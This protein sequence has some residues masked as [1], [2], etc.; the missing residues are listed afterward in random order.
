M[1]AWI[2]EALAA[3]AATALLAGCS[4][5]KAAN[6]K[7]GPP[8]V[9]VKCV[10]PVERD[11][12]RTLLV[13]MA[14]QP[15]SHAELCARVDGAVELM[16]VDE[17][18]RVK[19][20]DVLFQ[21]DKQNLENKLEIS[22]QELAVMEASLLVSAID[23]EIAKAQQGKAEIDFNRAEHLY[24]ANAVSKD[25]H[26]TVELL[27]TEANAT[28]RKKEALLEYAKAKVGQA[29]SNYVIAKKELEDSMIKAPFDG[30]VVKVLTEL[31]EYA[32]KGEA[33]VRLESEGRLELSALL[34]SGLYGDIEAGRTMAEL[35]STSGYK[36]S[37]PVS[38]K[39][40]NVDS[41][42]RTFEVKV[43][44]PEKAPLVAGQLC[45]VSLVLR[46][47]K[48][49]G[50][51]S[52]CALPREGG[53]FAAFTVKDGKAVERKLKIGIREKDWIEVSSS[54]GA[55]DGLSFAVEGQSFLNDGSP[56]ETVK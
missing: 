42:S 30:V 38:Y 52:Q 5:G 31:W 29:K 9:K 45:E 49:L 12:K 46:T 14:V 8:P 20:G 27:S 3:L 28:V 7:A 40:P 35:S 34:S 25:R 16:N 37:L 41:S 56:V 36:A 4:D 1:K 43:A 54:E 51:P 32:D 44:L 13:Q 48:G 2:A 47:S 26:E 23:C 11:F 50:L 22:R 53:A 33:V 19:A 24:K 10:N 17:G 55:L 39:S 21:T 18:S 15:V 6:M